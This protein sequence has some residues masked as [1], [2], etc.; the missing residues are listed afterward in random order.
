MVVSERP[1][2]QG[3]RGAERSSY[4]SLEDGEEV[5][6][7]ELLSCTP[8]AVCRLSGRKARLLS[9][10]TWPAAKSITAV[11]DFFFFI[12]SPTLFPDV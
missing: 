10:S 2:L 8:Y 11:M 5:F 12:S 6:F 4:P 3:S 1:V 7:S 9:R